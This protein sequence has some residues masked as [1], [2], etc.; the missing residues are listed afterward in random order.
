MSFSSLPL[1][2]LMQSIGILAAVNRARRNSA[3]STQFAATMLAIVILLA[4]WG[5][6]TSWLAYRGAYSGVEFLNAWPAFWITF[7]P[8]M[9]FMAPF[10]LS[11]GY[12]AQMRSLLDVTPAHWLTAIHTLRILAIGGIY[13]G[14][15]GEFSFYYAMLIGIP[16]LLFGAAAIWM[17]L[18]AAQKKSS[19]RELLAFHIVGALIILPFGVVLLQM[20]LP[21]PWQF[22]SGDPSIA[23]I[24]AFPM[25]LAPTLVVPLFVVI[26]LFA[27][28]RLIERRLGIGSDASPNHVPRD[29]Q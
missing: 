19:D 22:F 29:A 26:N 8:P 7:V 27:A 23:S 16:D 11:R 21:G 5:G 2:F 9:L 24:F 3:V 14:L 13:K 4:L 17:T 25:A 10:L 6:A 15:T 12:R 1:I 18:R 20:G 28:Q